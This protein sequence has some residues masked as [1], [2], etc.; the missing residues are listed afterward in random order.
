M[1]LDSL[2]KAGRRI[3]D[4]IATGVLPWISI[5][6][7]DIVLTVAISSSTILSASW[8]LDSFDTLLETRAK[9]NPTRRG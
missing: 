5:K 9:P 8:H 4:G 3:L 2:R 1:E 6:E 7:N